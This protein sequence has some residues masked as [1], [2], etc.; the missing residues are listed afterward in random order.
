MKIF[1]NDDLAVVE[2]LKEA[3]IITRQLQ[4]MKNNLDKISSDNLIKILNISE[5]IEEQFKELK[6]ES[7]G[8]LTKDGWN[9]HKSL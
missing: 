7:E 9:L 5:I 1:K 8:V 2:F 6:N 3:R 4:L